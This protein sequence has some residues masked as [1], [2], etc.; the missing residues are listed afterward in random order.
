MKLVQAFL[1]AESGG[2]GIEYAIIAAGVGLGICISLY[3]TGAMLN[4]RFEAIT[5]ALRRQNN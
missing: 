4:A 2:G 3:E 1:K 5:A